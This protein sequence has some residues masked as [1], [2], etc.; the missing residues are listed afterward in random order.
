[1]GF[2]PCK[3]EPDIWIREKDSLYE[4]TDV[5]V[6]DLAIA[7]KNSKESNDTIM[8]K[9]DFKLKGSGPIK[10]QLGCDLFRDDTC[11]L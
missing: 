3:A 11:T 9:H 5:Y 4:Y 7:V 10:Y 2:F 1:M 6:Y 8:N